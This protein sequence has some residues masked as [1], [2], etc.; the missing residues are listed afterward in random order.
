M[1]ILS[2]GKGTRLNKITKKIPKCL[3]E[4]NGKPFLYYQLH[5]LKKNNIKNVILSVGYKSNLIKKYIRK[6]IDFINVKVVNDGKKLL[7]TGGAI[8][9]SIKLLKDQ[10]FVIYGDSYINFKLNDLKKNKK[11]SIMAIYKNENKYDLSNVEK[12]KNNFIIYDKLKKEKNI[13]ILIM[14]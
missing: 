11:F 14:E 10:F 8:L 3:I 5:Y 12:L 2:G 13:D 4:F 9:K 7:G 1:I 6:E